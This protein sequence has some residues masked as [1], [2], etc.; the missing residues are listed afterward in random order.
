[1]EKFTNSFEDSQKAIVDIKCNVVFWYVFSSHAH[2]V[3]KDTSNYRLADENEI[4]VLKKSGKR[5][6]LLG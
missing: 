1:M 4:K 6:I 3:D 5:E 2:T